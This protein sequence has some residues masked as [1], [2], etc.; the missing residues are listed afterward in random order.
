MSQYFPKP[1]EPFERVINTKVDLSNYV[2]KTDL[3]NV[4]HIDASSLA[5]KSFIFLLFCA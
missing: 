2:A 3:R 1:C 4:T 5:L